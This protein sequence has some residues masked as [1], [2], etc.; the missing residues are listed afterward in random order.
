[1]SRIRII[2]EDQA[3][4]SLAKLYA[5]IAGS[6]GGVANVLKLHSLLPQ[7]MAD[8]FRLYKTLMFGL[9]KETG[10]A[11]KNLEMV[12][13]VVS[14]TNQCDYCVVHHSEPL[15]RLLKDETLVM[16]L[17]QTD[18]SYLEQHLEPRWLLVL[19][20]AQL[21]TRSPVEIS[22]HHIESLGEFFSDEQ[23][24]HLV[25]VVNY[26]NFVNRNVM[27][28]GINLEHDFQKTTR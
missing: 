7:T 28:L 25:L 15:K 3:T 19:N 8:H 2:S 24:L 17:G 22:D 12:A 16:A 11:R 10:I 13:V 9:S 1:M 20:F 4:G 14:V 18:W 27:A 23:I 21:L 26:F 5:S 6:R